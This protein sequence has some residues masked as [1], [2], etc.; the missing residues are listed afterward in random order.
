MLVVGAPVIPVG[1]LVGVF[2]VTV[3]LAVAVGIPHDPPSAR[4]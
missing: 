4:T 2:N 3:A 1:E